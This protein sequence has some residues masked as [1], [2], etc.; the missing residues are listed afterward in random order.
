MIQEIELKKDKLEHMFYLLTKLNTWKQQGYR[1]QKSIHSPGAVNFS[2][3]CL[4]A[5]YWTTQTLIHGFE[6]E[7]NRPPSS[8]CEPNNR[9]A[10]AHMAQLRKKFLDW[11]ME[12]KVRKCDIKPDICSPLSMVAKID[13]QALYQISPSSRSFTHDQ[14]LYK[15]QAY[16]NK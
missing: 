8:Y 15:R 1:V 16:Q 10:K 7:L 2:K 14:S 12:G 13:H 4:K 5:D 6:L 3:F 11:E 9:S